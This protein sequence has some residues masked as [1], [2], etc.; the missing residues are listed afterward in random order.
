MDALPL[1][2]STGRVLK[3]WRAMMLAVESSWI[4]Y[5]R[6][7]RSSLAS[8]LL[9]PLFFLVAMGFGLGSRIQPGTVTG[10]LS[11]AAYLAPALLASAAVQNAA[12]ESTFPV[13]SAFRWSKRYWGMTA[14]PLTPGQIAAGQLMWIALRLTFSGVV[15]V[16]VAAVLG[17]VAGPA[18]LVSLVFSVLAGMAF[19]APLLAY[20]A[21]IET[22]GQSFNVVFRF[23]VLPMTLISG[24]FFPLTALPVWVRPLAWVTPLW[25]GTELSRGVVL[26]TLELLPALGHLAYLIVLLVVGTVLAVWQ[27]RRRLGV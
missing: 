6:N 5:R 17:A 24:T 8:S 18:V 15:F 25:H 9:S 4:W 10:G 13:L 14:T 3:P 16:I 21:T 19:A 7:W 2:R 1:S 26:G 23:I 12:G 11:Y 20:S 27:F 22:E